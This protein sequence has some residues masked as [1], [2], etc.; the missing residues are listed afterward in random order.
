MEKIPIV[1][2]EPML[3][4]VARVLMF[5][6]KA[7]VISASAVAVYLAIPIYLIVPL[8]SSP[9]NLISKI[10]FSGTETYLLSGEV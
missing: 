8:I 2:A 10:T 5:A 9:G 6:L 3:E 4:P 7:F 1:S